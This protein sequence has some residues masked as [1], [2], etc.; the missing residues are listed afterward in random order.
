MG[1]TGRI[2]PGHAPTMARPSP[3]PRTLRR[4][5]RGYPSTPSKGKRT[6]PDPRWRAATAWPISLKQ[7]ARSTPLADQG[8]SALTRKWLNR[9]SQNAG[10]TWERMQR[11]MKRYPLPTPRIVHSALA[12]AA[13]P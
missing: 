4:S 9:R 7:P 8:E 10:M 6:N 5:W 1:V 12:R 2:R 3:Q 11:L 13:N